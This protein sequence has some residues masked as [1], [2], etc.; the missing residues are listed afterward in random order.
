MSYKGILTLRQLGDTTALYHILS[1]YSAHQMSSTEEMWGSMWTSCMLGCLSSERR[2]AERITERGRRWKRPLAEE[3]FIL[4]RLNCIEVVKYC[5]KVFAYLYSQNVSSF[6]PWDSTS[7]WR[8][9][10][11]FTAHNMKRQ[12][13]WFTQET[14]AN[15]DHSV[16]WLLR[17][18][19]KFKSDS[20]HLFTLWNFSAT[21]RND[22]KIIAN[23]FSFLFFIYFI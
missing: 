11:S 2:K 19:N 4:L 20:L 7:G 13:Q 9:S 17:C 12:N 14:A 6:M 3:T 8:S 23:K 16:P 22:R 10:F 21:L 5:S 1:S 15:E 18:L